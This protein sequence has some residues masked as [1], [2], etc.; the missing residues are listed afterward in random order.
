M[1]T[2][3]LKAFHAIDGGIREILETLN[4]W[5]N[6]RIKADQ[7]FNVWIDERDERLR[8]GGQSVEKQIAAYDAE[9]GCRTSPVT[10]PEPVE[11][12]GALACYGRS[13]P[14]ISMSM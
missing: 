9:F 4:R 14:S 13:H 11:G 10:G 1:D 8:Q 7:A 2:Q 5:E 3:I 6:K 12:S